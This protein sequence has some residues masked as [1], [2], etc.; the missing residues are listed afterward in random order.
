MIFPILIY[1]NENNLFGARGS[2]AFWGGGGGGEFLPL[3]YLRYN[4]GSVPFD[5]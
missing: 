4:S 3:K 1:C 2:W 5:F